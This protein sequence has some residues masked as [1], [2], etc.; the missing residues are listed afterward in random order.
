[1][2]ES[3][4]SVAM[5]GGF[6]WAV[7]F[8]VPKA[9]KEDD[10]LA[11]GSAILTAGV[12]L[13][14]WLLMAVGVTSQNRIPPSWKR[15]PAGPQPGTAE[16]QCA[17]RTETSWRVSFRDGQLEAVPLERY[18]PRRD[19]L[20]Y[21]I[22][23]STVLDPPPPSPPGSKTGMT[24]SEWAKGYARDR[25][26]RQVMQVKDG[27]LVGFDGGEYGGSLWWY[28]PQPAPG[29]KLW[30]HNVKGL[31]SG[32]DP[33]SVIALAGLAHLDSSD[34]TVLWLGQE[35]DGTWRVEDQRALLGAPYAYGSHPSGL[36]IATDT[37]VELVLGSKAIQVLAE[38]KGV[39]VH[40][41]SIAVAPD[42]DI[43]VGLRFFVSLLRK[44]ASVYRQEWFIPTGCVQFVEE[45]FGCRCKGQ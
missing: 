23:F 44:D 5:L 9:L 25:A 16:Y 32:Q 11:T 14:G 29:R 30:D 2:M 27:W 6:L 40:P 26:R 37:S 17:G 38:T 31:V 35:S 3:V 15:L 33:S 4:L 42:G 7:G 20:P 21:A 13:L 18:E 45:D 12:A 36:V 39:D 1:M 8:L 22:D 43:A 28:P 24:P 10:P 41:L 19:A 34:G